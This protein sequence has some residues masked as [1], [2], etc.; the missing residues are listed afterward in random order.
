MSI[1]AGPRAV[2]QVGENG[3]DDPKFRFPTEA[4]CGAAMVPIEGQTTRSKPVYMGY[5]ILI[6]W[7]R[8]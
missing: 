5:K 4:L 7:K 3:H 1:G 8:I 6:A 2:G